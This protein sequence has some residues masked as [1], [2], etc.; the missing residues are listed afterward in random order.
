MN[1]F[2]IPHPIFS[3]VIHTIC[4]CMLFA[5]IDRQELTKFKART[6]LILIPW[7][8][9]FWTFWCVYLKKSWKRWFTVLLYYIPM[10]CWF[11]SPLVP[12]FIFFIKFGIQRLWFIMDWFMVMQLFMTFVFIFMIQIVFDCGCRSFIFIIRSC[13]CFLCCYPCGLC[14][15]TKNKKKT[16][17]YKKK[18]RQRKRKKNKY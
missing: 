12:I 18:K 17:S 1:L 5:T 6:F 2:E 3:T 13:L 14:C 16:P 10:I 4:L 9:G 7:G 8:F 11:F 15:Y